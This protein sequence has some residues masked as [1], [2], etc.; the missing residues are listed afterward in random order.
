MGTNYLQNPGTL[1]IDLMLQGLRSTDRSI[2]DS[3]ENS[4][5]D[6][7]LP[8]GIRV[9]VP[10]GGVFTRN[11]PYELI[12]TGKGYAVTDGDDSIKVTLAGNPAFY[13][14]QTKS[15][16]RFSDIATVHGSYVVITPQSGCEF[17]EEGIECTYCAGNF[18]KDG[19]GRVFSIDDILEVVEA[20][21]KEK[22]AGIIYLSIGFSKGS[23]GGIQFL[24]PYIEAIKKFFNVLVAVEALP[25]KRNQWIDHTY[26]IGADSILYNIEIFDK[27]LF[28]VICPGRS[29]LIGRNRYLNALKYAATV[30]PS[31]TV[32]SHLIVG[33]EPP[34]S[35]RMG[36]DYLTDMGV[37]PILPIYRPAAGRALRIEPLTT[38]IILPV[39]RHLYKTVRDR[40]INMNWVR[41]IS[42]ITT[43]IEG[44]ALFGDGDK[45]GS[46]FF[47]S[48]YK[49]RLGRKTAWGLSTLRRK[50]RVK[51][52]AG[53]PDETGGSGAKSGE[54][55]D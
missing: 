37:V 31:G 51:G 18:D 3:S 40:K 47:E 26:A 35:T 15:G 9:N 2:T 45:E 43:P 1:K 13:S 52:A 50:L 33:L 12:K 36:I 39:Y 49:S 55:D 8:G 53:P 21:K 20:V 16:V 38:E 29:K 22:I 34:G 48:F 6:I 5:L 41:D 42:V 46:K 25:P 54:G 30:F 32:A 14:R 44:R 7:V 17:F 27:E 23:D 19:P 24:T 11:S 28:E 4:G 10:C